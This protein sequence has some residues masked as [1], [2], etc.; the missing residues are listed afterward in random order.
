MRLEGVHYLR[1]TI[2]HSAGT[3]VS[4][5]GLAVYRFPVGSAFGV[6]G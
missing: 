2:A 5:E 1:K 4:N 6:G 3:G